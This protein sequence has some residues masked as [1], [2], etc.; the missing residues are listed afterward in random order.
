MNARRMLALTVSL[1]AA[2]AWGAPALAHAH[3]EGST[4]A[5][6]AEIGMAPEEMSMTFSEPVA[7]AGVTLTKADGSEVPMNYMP[8]HEPSA[9]QSMHLPTLEPGAYSLNCRVLGD[10][11]HVTTQTIG[12]TVTG[13]ADGGHMEGARVGGMHGDDGEMHG[14]AGMHDEGGHMH[15][16]H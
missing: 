4:I 1:A 7:I 8:S 6:G 3:L 16:D 11:G 2:A 15:D 10:D 12:F 14:A 9:M 13:M 5:D